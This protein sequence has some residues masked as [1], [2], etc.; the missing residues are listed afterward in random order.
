MLRNM[1]ANTDSPFFRTNVL[2]VR[3]LGLA[4]EPGGTAYW[5]RFLYNIET[6]APDQRSNSRVLD[7]SGEAF[8]I[9]IASG[10]VIF[11]KKTVDWSCCVVQNFLNECHYSAE[12]L[13]IFCFYTPQRCP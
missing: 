4:A 1:S 9:V 6:P 3:D 2:L 13:S 7:T 5:R 12:M 8:D 10:E 11:R